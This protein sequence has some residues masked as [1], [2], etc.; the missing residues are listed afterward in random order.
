LE[1]DIT[2]VRNKFVVVLAGLHVKELEIAL[3]RTSASWI[4]L[5]RSRELRSCHL[6][7]LHRAA[8]YRVNFFN[9]LFRWRKLRCTALGLTLGLCHRRRVMSRGTPTTSMLPEELVR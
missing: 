6:R 1:Q 9:L 7:R 2:F 4:K 8:A 3:G 5:E